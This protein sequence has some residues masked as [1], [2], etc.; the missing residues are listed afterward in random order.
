LFKNPEEKDLCGPS[1]LEML[2]HKGKGS[3]P[4]KSKM[5]YGS[6]PAGKKR[7]KKMMKKKK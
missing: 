1:P 2:M 3:C 5:S 7:G 4:G 6:K